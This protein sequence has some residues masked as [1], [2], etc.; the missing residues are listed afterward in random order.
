MKLELAHG[1][2]D[3]DLLLDS[4][5]IA[6]GVERDLVTA[7]YGGVGSDLLEFHRRRHRELEDLRRRLAAAKLGLT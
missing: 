3:L 1:A 7:A 4:L 2:A 5:R 6:I